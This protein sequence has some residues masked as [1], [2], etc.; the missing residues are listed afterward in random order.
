MRVYE[1]DHGFTVRRVSIINQALLIK[2]KK[3]VWYATL[4]AS[5]PYSPV[6]LLT[7]PKG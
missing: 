1:D 7:I 2:A 6:V 5:G 4:F 3:Q